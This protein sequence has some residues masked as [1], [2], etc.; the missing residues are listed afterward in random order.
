MY[1]MVSKAL[2]RGRIVGAFVS[3]GQAII[4]M[5]K[6]ALRGLIFSNAQVLDNGRIMGNIDSVRL[7]LKHLYHGSRGGLFGN[8]SVNYGRLECDFGQGFYVGDNKMQAMSIICDEPIGILYDMDI[9]TNYLK[10]YRF[11]DGIVWALYVGVNRGFID[12]R[13]YKKLMKICDFIDTNDIV[14]G[15][16]ADDRMNY[17]F[18]AFISGLITDSA[19][20]ESLKFVNLGSQYVFKNDLAAKNIII[21]QRY[22]LSDDIKKQLVKEHKRQIGKIGSTINEIWLRN[23]RSG[24]FIDEL[25]EGFR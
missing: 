21:K 7:K 16:I 24:K 23:R 9:I 22:V 6:S 19:L 14:C 20:I 17:V 10:V 15:Y 11:D 13:P 8:I 18:N 25:L 2:Y 5:E 1:H 3:D 12:K 4:F